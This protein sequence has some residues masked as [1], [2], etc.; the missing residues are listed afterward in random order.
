MDASRHFTAKERAI[1]DAFLELLTD[2][3]FDALSNWA[4]PQVAGEP[5]SRMRAA[6]VPEKAVRLRQRDGKK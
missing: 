3:E 2:E 5:T 4:F 1:V 6:I